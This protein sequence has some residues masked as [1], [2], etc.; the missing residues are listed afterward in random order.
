MKSKG[1]TSTPFDAQEEVLLRRRSATHDRGERHVWQKC[2]RR[3][4]WEEIAAT[5]TL[6]RRNEGKK[7][8][9]VGARLT[10]VGCA[11]ARVKAFRTHWRAICGDT[12]A[13]VP[14]RPTDPPRTTTTSTT[15]TTTTTTSAST[16]TT[17]ATSTTTQT[18][19]PTT[20]AAGADYKAELAALSDQHQRRCRPLLNIVRTL[21]KGK[22]GGDDGV[23]SDFFVA[24]HESHMC[25]L[26][27]LVEKRLQGGESAPT[28]W[29][30][31]TVTLIPKISNPVAAGD[32]RPISPAHDPESDPADLDE[33]GSTMVRTPGS[34]IPW[35]S[36]RL[37]VRRGPCG[38]SPAT[39]SQNGVGTVDTCRTT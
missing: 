28:S 2:I 21:P 39:S 6:A 26:H 18:P 12:A 27:R 11:E 4:R 1:R 17:T 5:A 20:T 34:H 32:F 9:L 3:W 36:Q 24:V 15:T 38:G 29:A 23:L 7:P 16:S 19:T 37:P 13:D 35:V 10:G 30:R 14:L 25:D 8:K 33:T 31:A 22:A